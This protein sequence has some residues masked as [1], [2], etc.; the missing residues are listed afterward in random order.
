V[1]Y[2]TLGSNLLWEVASWIF[3]MGWKGEPFLIRFELI[4]S[5]YC[6]LAALAC[7]QLNPADDLPQKHKATH[8]WRV[9]DHGTKISTHDDAPCM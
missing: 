2:V 8:W 1:K 6:S 5:G 9:F 7:L 3:S 4:I